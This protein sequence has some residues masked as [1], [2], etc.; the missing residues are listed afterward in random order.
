[1]FKEF[2]TKQIWRCFWE[3]FRLYL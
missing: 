2:M 3:D 1:M